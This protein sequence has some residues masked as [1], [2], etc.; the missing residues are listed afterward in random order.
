MLE[1]KNC[2]K[3]EKFFSGNPK[4]PF[5]KY[6]KDKKVLIVG[7]FPKKDAQDFFY[8]KK[9]ELFKS[10]ERLNEYLEIIG[11]NLESV[12]FTEICK[13]TVDN[14]KKLKKAAENCYVHLVKQIEI[15]KP[16]IVITIGVTAKEIFSNKNHK[17]IKMGQVYR[18]KNYNY[19]PLY[20]PSPANPVGHKSNLKIIFDKKTQLIVLLK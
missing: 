14:R 2:K 3:C 10:S 4:D 5:I 9:K 1:I 20:H 6:G 16:R 15:L 12:S 7:E 13:C 18:L 17:K 11:L 19:L 8:N